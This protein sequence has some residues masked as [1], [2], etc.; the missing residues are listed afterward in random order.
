MCVD[1]SSAAGSG[2]LGN[3]DDETTPDELWS[4]F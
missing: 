1:A 3:A 4:L 2:R